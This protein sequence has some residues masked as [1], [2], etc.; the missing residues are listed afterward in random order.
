MSCTLFWLVEGKLIRGDGLYLIGSYMLKRMHT[1]FQYNIPLHVA[2]HLEY[3]TITFRNRRP[4]VTFACRSIVNGGLVTLF[5][6]KVL[7]FD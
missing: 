3:I 7:G 4:H 2:L 1:Q 6:R 5:A